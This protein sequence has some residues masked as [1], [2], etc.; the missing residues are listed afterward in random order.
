ME[1]TGVS[2]P[3]K[4]SCRVQHVELRLEDR[5][6][7][8]CRRFRLRRGGR[9]RGPACREREGDRSGGGTG[10]RRAAGTQPNSA[11]EPGNINEAEASLSRRYRQFERILL[12]MAEYL[13]KTEPERADLLI[14]AIGK[15]KE[16]RVGLQMD[17]ILEL[18]KSD[19]LGDAIGR[20]EH[21]VSN[22]K[23]L[24]ELLQSE[25]RR[26]QLEEEKKWIESL[27]K[28]VGKLSTREKE[29][30][31][32]TEG[33]GKLGPLCERQGKIGRD[34]KSLVEKIDKQDAARNASNKKNLSDKSGKS[35]DGRD[36]K[37]SSGQAESR[38]PF[39]A[40]G[41]W[42]EIARQTEIGRQIGRPVPQERIR[43]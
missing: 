18:L 13:R 22:L 8:L 32:A 3:R 25:D 16:D 37:E 36:T 5:R 21:L 17:Q 9:C 43:R 39:Q 38:R 26:H 41:E 40:Q 27:H 31:R 30:R 11:A 20:Q 6:S 33:G 35:P 12:Q 10:L 23:G 24:L 14:R 4:G 42:R 34:A 15:S 19:Q 2:P 1:I 7:G 29:L 28:E